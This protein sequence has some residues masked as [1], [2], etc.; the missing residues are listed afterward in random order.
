[1][2]VGTLPIAV[3]FTPNENYA[4]V[5]N[6]SNNTV[7]WIENSS[8]NSP[9]AST[10]FSVGTTPQAVAITPNGQY[11]YVTNFNSVSVFQNASTNPSVMTKITQCIG[12]YP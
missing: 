6:N 9:T 8:T 11:A 5:V 1:M 3:A 12:P 10:T 7:S 2:G 4:Y